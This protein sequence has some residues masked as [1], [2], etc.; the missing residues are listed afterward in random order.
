MEKYES[1]ITTKRLIYLTSVYICTMGE[2]VVENLEVS[3]ETDNG[4]VYAV[5]KVSFTIPNDT[6]IGLLGESGCGK[7]T[8]SKSIIKD[9]PSNGNIDSGE[10]L[11]AGENIVDLSKEEL[12][13][14]RWEEIAYVP[15]NAM[16]CLDPVYTIEN[17]LIETIS[18]H[19]D[20]PK[21]K[22][23]EKAKEIFDMVGID[24]SRLQ[25][26][27]HEMSGGMK[28]RIVL[29]LAFILDPGLIIADEPTTGLDVLIRDKILADI[30]KYQKEFDVS[31]LIV[32]HD[33]ADLVETCDHLM[34]MYGGKIVEKSSSNQLIQNPT[35]PYTMGLINSTPRL[36]TEAHDLISMSMDPPDLQSPP[37]GCRFI[38]KC[39]FEVPECSNA[40]PDL[41]ETNGSAS[42][43]FRANDS[44]EI[45]AHI[46]NEGWM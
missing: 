10:I 14:I 1:I 38:D 33:I 6:I 28:Q 39:P 43:C 36:E 29:A 31:I 12:Q 20:L 2:L 46:Q 45:H 24:K 34:V 40:H 15:Q 37:A 25:D 27:P 19:R 11:Y 5:D 26:Y 23:V 30:E 3:Y 41:T 9:L 16:N 35:H 17:Q 42:A 44:K 22:K 21:R 13:A 18:A 32:S 8:L 7:S 4:N